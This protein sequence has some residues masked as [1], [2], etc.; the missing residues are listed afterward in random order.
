MKAY[1][2]V[3]NVVGQLRIPLETYNMQNARQDFVMPA[4]VDRV[5]V[6]YQYALGL[7]VT[8]EAMH[9]LQ[10]GCF[11]VEDM[12]SL[13]EDARSY[14]L[15]ANKVENPILSIKEVAIL[16]KENNIDKIES[17]I[18]RGQPVELANLFTLVR[19]NYDKI[20]AGILTKIETLCGV[21]LK[22]DE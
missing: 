18:K 20:S 5:I 19:E 10:I 1:T 16:L 22:I 2:F 4:G 9:Q 8:P 21:D 13:I 14:G 11:T 17:L 15:V 12:D 6:P 7:F 3:K